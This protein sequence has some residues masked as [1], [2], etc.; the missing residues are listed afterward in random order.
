MSYEL[1]YPGANMKK[2]MN[3]KTVVFKCPR[4]IDSKSLIEQ[5]VSL[6][7]QEVRTTYNGFNKQLNSPFGATLFEYWEYVREL[8]CPSDQVTCAMTLRYRLLN[9][10][11]R[12]PHP[13]FRFFS[14]NIFHA[15]GF[16][17][18]TLID[19]HGGI[20]HIR[21]LHVSPRRCDTKNWH[22]VLNNRAL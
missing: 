20:H 10:V 9:S 17:I 1:T 4:S 18:W 5:P 11:T 2:G 15:C 3:F 19:C 13:W 8:F 22:V 14:L 12:V 6:T 7:T 21:Y 16:S